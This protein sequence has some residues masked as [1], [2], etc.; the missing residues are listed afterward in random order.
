MCIT[1]NGLKTTDA[2][3]GQYELPEPVRP[4]LTDFENYLQRESLAPA[5]QLQDLALTA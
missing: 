3:A 4:R 1:G 2:L 5:A